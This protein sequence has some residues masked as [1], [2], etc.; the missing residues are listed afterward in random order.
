M[1]CGCGKKKTAGVPAE[2][3]R[4]AREVRAS[5]RVAEYQVVVNGE[6]V[7]KT[8]SASAASAE[9]RRL[10][11]SVRVGSRPAA[12]EELKQPVPA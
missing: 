6:V 11:G 3:Q 10:S 9:A 1:G 8:D 12:P 4:Q 2:A 7:T 5:G